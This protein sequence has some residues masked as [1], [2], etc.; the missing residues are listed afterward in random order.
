M[1][2]KLQMRL[3]G[4]EFPIHRPLLAPVSLYFQQVLSSEWMESKRRII[5]VDIDGVTPAE[6][7]WVLKNTYGEESKALNK[8]Q[9]E[10]TLKIASYF[11]LE[12][13]IHR[14]Q[15]VVRK[16]ILTASELI[17]LQITH[18]GVL[19]SVADVIQIED[20]DVERLLSVATSVGATKMERRCGTALAEKLLVKDADVD[21]VAKLP[22][23]ALLGCFSSDNMSGLPNEDALFD[24]IYALC[25]AQDYPHDVELE[26]A[27]CVRLQFL[28]VHGIEKA[29]KW[30]AIDRNSIIAALAK[31]RDPNA[32][33]EVARENSRRFYVAFSSDLS[34]GSLAFHDS[35][36]TVTHVSKVRAVAV[37]DTPCERGKVV[38]VTFV[39]SNDKK[40]D[41]GTCFGVVSRLEVGPVDYREAVGPL[42]R[43]YNGEIRENRAVRTE[44]EKLH[45]KDIATLQI[46]GI[47]KKVEFIKD[48]KSLATRDCIPDSAWPLCPAVWFYGNNEKVVVQNT[49]CR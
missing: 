14:I 27:A 49:A 26:F 36:T 35:C 38:K 4:K 5:S 10:G 23:S 16:V 47:L 48:G 7:E 43:A 46:D 1:K 45:P 15:E 2:K 40:G 42:W 25:A 41:E 18:S 22:I 32:F 12:P 3:N 34:K 20:E 8:N 17:D 29:S 13:L 24:L 33:S 44:I 28:S 11:Q 21:E 31:Q 9:I 19:D 6:F 37:V 39:L 30:E